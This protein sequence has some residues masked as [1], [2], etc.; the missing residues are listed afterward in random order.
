MCV[1]DARR[2]AHGRIWTIRRFCDENKSEN[3]K[4]EVQTNTNEY[5]KVF[6]P[7]FDPEKVEMRYPPVSE[8]KKRIQFSSRPPPPRPAV[9]QSPSP[10]P[11]VLILGSPP[12]GHALAFSSLRRGGGRSLLLFPSGGGGVGR[13]ENDNVVIVLVV[14][15]FIVLVVVVVVVVVVILLPPTMSG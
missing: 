4:R 12:A 10:Y 9:P 7:P 2:G 3:K 6:F 13:E 8:I 14:V 1:G 5:G 11:I 15:V